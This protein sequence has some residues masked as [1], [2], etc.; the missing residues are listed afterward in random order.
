MKPSKLSRNENCLMVICFGLLTKNRIELYKQ[1]L[2]LIIPQG[3]VL[4][5]ENLD[6][7]YDYSYLN[8]CGLRVILEKKTN[9]KTLILLRKTHDDVTSTKQ[10]LY[11]NNHEFLWVENLKSMMKQNETCASM[12]I[13]LVAE[14]DYTC[15]LLGF[16]NCLRKEPGGEMIR[17]VFIQDKK[18]LFSLEEPLYSKQLQLDLP[19]NVL[20]PGNV[21][22]TYR[23]FSL[24]LLEPKLV[25]TALVSQAVRWVFKELSFAT[26]YV[27]KYLYLYSNCMPQ[28]YLYDIN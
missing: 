25:E 14:Q 9:D 10:V 26:F 4:T 28:I 17:S 19:I 20:R 2:S 5:L 21:W 24:P 22:G 15:G 11:L 3:F 13:I 7:I 1:L 16:V 6:A 18:A 8:K 23:H 27:D 12:R